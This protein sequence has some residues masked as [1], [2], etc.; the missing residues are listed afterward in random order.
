MKRKNILFF[1]HSTKDESLVS[2][3][4]DLLY[5]IGLTE[6][7][8]FCSS[9]SDIGV[10]MQKDIYKY[11]RN[12]LN[13]ENIIPVFMLSDNYYNSPA[14][15]NEMGAVWVKQKKYFTFLLPGF[16]FTE[17]KGAINPNQKSIKLD[18]HNKQLKS[19]LNS[20]KD[21]ICDLFNKTISE[22]KWEKQRDDFISK[23]SLS[24]SITINL[25]EYEG[26]CINYV[27]YGGCNAIYDEVTNKVMVTYDFSKTDAEICSLVF[28]TGELDVSTNFNSNGEL[29][30][31][32]RSKYHNFPLTV[33][34][35]LKNRDTR[36]KIQASTEWEN[37]SIPLKKFGS[38]KSEWTKLKEIKFLVYRNE[39]SKE[40]IEIKNI[41]LV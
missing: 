14:C 28:F 17:I 16:N 5:S 34:V 12:L 18:I 23:L 19:E 13:Y 11:L 15:L 37:F 20:F 21:I 32:L 2:D 25:K 8:M 40:T 1:S 4:V 9:R 33:E 22:N 24:H 27:N 6:A 30:F 31:S 29:C 10:P 7:E 38:I 35:R 41:K 39:I 36:I 26:Y 3:F